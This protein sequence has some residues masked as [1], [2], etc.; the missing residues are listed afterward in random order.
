M[1][2]CAA[3]S[4]TGVARGVRRGAWRFAHAARCRIR[5]PAATAQASRAT[6]DEQDMPLQPPGLFPGLSGF[7]LGL[8][9]IDDLLPP[10]APLLK[11]SLS[12]S[13]LEYCLETKYPTQV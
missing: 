8:A 6:M 13:S 7:S 11:K 1:A 9:D 2:P 3:T 12:L 5:A 4:R 10:D